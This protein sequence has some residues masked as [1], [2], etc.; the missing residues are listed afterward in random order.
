MI[1]IYGLVCPNCERYTVLDDI[2]AQEVVSKRLEIIKRKW[3]EA[4]IDMDK[5]EMLEYVFRD[6]ARKFDE[7]LGSSYVLNTVDIVAKT[8]LM[9]EIMKMKNVDETRSKKPIKF[10]VL[11]MYEFII[12]EKRYHRHIKSGLVKI[13]YYTKYRADHMTEKELLNCFQPCYTEEYIMLK[14]MHKKNNLMTS[15]EAENIVK[16]DRQKIEEIKKRHKPK[17]QTPEERIKNGYDVIHMCHTNLLQDDVFL[18]V[19]NLEPCKKIITN[20]DQLE[21]FVLTTFG[22][23]NRCSETE[24]LSNA[25]NIFKK[26]IKTLKKSLLFEESNP[27]IFP[28]F[29]KIT[30]NSKKNVLID[31]SMT[32]IIHLMLHAVI[33]KKEFDEETAKRGKEFEIITRKIFE[34]HGF[35]YF[36]N[37]IKKNKMEIDGIA[38]RDDYCFVIEVKGKIIP[39]LSMEQTR[40]AT[41]RRDLKGIVDGYKY[42]HKIRKKKPSMIEKMEHVKQ[43]YE[44]FGMSDRDKMNFHGVVVTRFYQGLP[45]YNDVKFITYDEL[46]ECLS[47]NNLTAMVCDSK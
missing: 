11:N 22:E 23:R 28:W 26:N 10:E 40:R 3:K 4:I 21:K 12:N 35:K 34:K 38:V 1:D 43:N 31:H 19:F 36:K 45:E 14:N 8:Q 24:F 7:F 37:I 2:S 25:H 41:L 30:N 18:S 17:S 15:E 32:R 9:Q 33:L 39:I 6:R 42:T 20:P 5:M 47:K 13:L 46:E 16:K 27:D 44:K 29:L